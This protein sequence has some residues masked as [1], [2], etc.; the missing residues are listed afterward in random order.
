M[1]AK[2]KVQV[3]KA[4]RKA[5]PVASMNQIKKTAMEIVLGAL[6]RGHHFVIFDID[7]CIADDEWRFQFCQEDESPDVRYEHYH[8]ASGR[9][10]ALSAGLSA[11]HGVRSTGAFPI[12]ITARPEKFRAITENWLLN[13]IGVDVAK[14]G[15]LFMRHNGDTGGSVDI[16]SNITAEIINAANETR[17]QIKIIAAYDDRAD[18]VTMYNSVFGINAYVLDKDGVKDVLGLRA[19]LTRSLVHGHCI[20]SLA[21]QAEPSTGGNVGFVDDGRPDV[22]SYAGGVDC[23]QSRSDYGDVEGILRDMAD[24]FA[25]RNAAYGN[26]GIKVGDVMTALFP[27]GVSASSEADH[28]MWHLFQLVIVKLTRFVNSGLKHED[29]A[30][31]AG[32][33]FAMCQAEIK[34]HNL[35][36]GL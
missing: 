16:K 36:C 1:V 12:F 28:R 19:R 9:D 33:Y 17:H 22:A 4:V 24:T 20:D 11:W 30:R 31:D 5:N 14:D 3:K 7:G 32:V 29:S 18:I 13:H 15:A 2:K 6:K 27:N 10:Q 35:R 23:V 26:N 21:K 34:H 25:E 8:A